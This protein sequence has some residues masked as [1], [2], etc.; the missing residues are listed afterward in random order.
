MK[1]LTKA[2]ALLVLV[3]F[4]I[5]TNAQKIKLREGSIAVLKGEASVNVEFTYDGM[6]VG[7]Y[8]DEQ[9]YIK[10]KTDDYNKKEP[11]T[12]DRFAKAWVGDRKTRLEPKF[13]ELFEEHSKML[14][15]PKSKYTLIFKTTSTEPGYNVYISR[16]N[17]EIDAE[18][19]LVE[20]ENRGTVLAT[21]MVYNA[22]GRTFGGYDYDTGSRLAEAYAAA[23]KRLGM[24]I[25]KGKD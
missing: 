20:T 15:K 17:A 23:G 2:V 7:S 4:S 6:S 16:K 24:F 19:T 18:V 12:G 14:I 8:S 21:I 25:E 11:G 13:K 9:E 22:P 5:N 1:L 3:F 10:K